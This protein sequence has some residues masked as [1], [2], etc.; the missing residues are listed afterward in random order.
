MK[1]SML[2]RASALACCLLFVLTCLQS[3]PSHALVAPSDSIEVLTETRLAA[4]TAAVE[5]GLSI[6]ATLNQ[7]LVSTPSACVRNQPDYACSG[8]LV[9]PMAAAH[10]VRFWE[11]DAEANARGSEAFVY[12]RS[13]RQQGAL[14]GRGGYVLMSRF[15]ALA[16]GKPYEVKA[17]PRPGEVQVNNWNAAQPNQIAIEAL[18]YNPAV[19]NDLFR[20]QRSQLQWFKATAAWLPILRYD[21]GVGARFGFDQSEQLYDGY[22]IAERINQRFTTVTAT[23]PD[24]RA[25]YYCQGVWVRTTNIAD[26]GRY[27]T[28]NPSPGSQRNNSVS[29]SWFSADTSVATTY[30]TQ[31]FILRESGYAV[32]QPLTLR[33]GYPRDAATSGAADPC[34]FR[35]QC[36]ALGITTTAAWRARYGS[37][38]NPGCAFGNDA[39]AFRVLIDLRNRQTGFVNAWNE[40]M[41]AVWPQ[42]VAAQL[43]LE[44]FIYSAANGRANAQVF[45]REYVRDTLGR[46]LPVLFL[47]PTPPPNRLVTYNPDDQNV[48]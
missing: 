29:F 44:S 23:C 6:A 1:K 41:M 7:R 3:P 21:G 18:Y 20:A 43:P 15:D 34:T 2:P 5:Q 33:C 14:P 35:G 45:Q 30:H 31:G 28:W 22:L 16:N 9:R 17:R 27:R 24:G 4:A 8:V 37:G 32:T 40:L 38:T 25:R 11:H 39:A 36:A 48:E 12:L 19:P 13:D 46:Y 42:N 47:N 26:V 10:A